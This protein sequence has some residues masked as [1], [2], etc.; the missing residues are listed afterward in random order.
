VIA[1]FAEALGEDHTIEL[2]RLQWPKASADPP[3]ARGLRILLD[4]RSNLLL[5][6]T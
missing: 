1:E 3:V 4:I 2:E 6:E 5:C